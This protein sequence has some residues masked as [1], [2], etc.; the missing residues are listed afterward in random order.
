MSDSTTLLR[1]KEWRFV[2]HTRLGLLDSALQSFAFDDTFCS[3]VGSGASAPIIRFWVHA[4][5]IVLGI[6]DA[7]LPFIRKGV[8]FLNENGYEVIIRNSG[9]LAV[10]LDEEILNISLILREGNGID[11]HR[12]YGAMWK[13]IQLMLADYPVN[14]EA[15][16]I[17]GSYCP[18]S[19]DLSIGNR[20]FAGI[21][22]RR[23]R[24][25]VAVQ[26]YICVS[27]SGSERA[28]LIRKFYNLALQ[29]TPTKMNYPII[30]P[31]TM[32]SLAELLK[33]ELSIEKTMNLVTRSLEK[34]GS[35]IITTPLAA[36]ELELFSYN[37]D[38][39]LKRNEKAW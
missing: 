21:S 6:Q 5:T 19:F 31:S 3:S 28:E 7:K 25:G 16:E 9:G 37:Y 18:G 4:P 17:V 14:I 30:V 13:L 1:Q 33:E 38:R 35:T 36:Q 2:D 34:V 8:A 39:I 23:L 27:G 22:Q 10:V 15:K 12:G 20:K 11:I 26:I 24:S 29:N 32:A